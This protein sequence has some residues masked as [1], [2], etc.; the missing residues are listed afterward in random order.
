MILVGDADAI[1]PPAL[2]DEMQRSIPGAELAVIPDAGHMHFI[3]QATTFN[4]ICLEFLR[5]HHA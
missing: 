3:E 1:T 2:S 4:D 5:K